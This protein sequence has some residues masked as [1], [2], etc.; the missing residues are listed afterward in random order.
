[1]ID[2][3]RESGIPLYAQIRDQFRSLILTNHLKP[4]FKLPSTRKLAKNIYVNRNTILNA[5]AELEAEGLIYSQSG[6]G[7][8]VSENDRLNRLITPNPKI[9]NKTEYSQPKKFSWPFAQDGIINFPARPHHISFVPSY[10]SEELLLSR[11]MKKCFYAVMKD[12][13]NNIFHACDLEGYW[14]L[15]E[16]LAK[17]LAATGIQTFPQNICVINGARQAFSLIT[18]ILIQKG[19]CVA[20]EAPTSPG[21][22]AIFLNRK[23]EIV[24]IPVEMDGMNIDIF[25]EYLKKKRFKVVFVMPN[26]HNPTGATMSLIKR[27]KMIDLA[28][29]YK[30]RIIEDDV[31]GDFRFEGVELPSLKSL[32]RTGQIVYVKSFSPFFPGFR[33]GWMI[34][35][36]FLK[37]QIVSIRRIEN[38]GTNILSQALLYKFYSRGYYKSYLRK[39]RKDFKAKR[40]FMQNNLHKHFPKC[41]HFLIPEG[42]PFLWVKFPQGIDLMKIYE[43]SLIAGIIFDPGWLFYNSPKE[44]Y[45]IRLCYLSNSY[46]NIE[47]GIRILGKIISGTL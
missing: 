3:K 5:Y 13:G 18:N 32:D 2:L 28:E 34:V 1:M 35:D 44:E 20:V 27:K 22:L 40:D 38:S 47:E 8:F 23:I 29:E 43:K 11:F 45:E 24:E 6:I 21:L 19:D 30:V 26:F 16:F 15:R 36:D 14:P 4:N 42:G 17:R 9:F 41:C 10:P 12:F 33:I 46:K 37:D 31:F 25:E 7:I 39:A